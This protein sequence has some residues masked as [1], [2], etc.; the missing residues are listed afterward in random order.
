MPIFQWE[1]GSKRVYIIYNTSLIFFPSFFFGW[2][3]WEGARQANLGHKLGLLDGVKSFWIYDRGQFPVKTINYSKRG[4]NNGF[5]F[6]VAGCYFWSIKELLAS[7]SL[8]T[9][10][11]LNLFGIFRRAVFFGYYFL[12]TVV[13]LVRIFRFFWGGGL[14]DLELPLK[15]EIH[16]NLI[17]V[18]S[19]QE[20]F[21]QRKN[22]PALNWKQYQKNMT[23]FHGNKRVSR[24]IIWVCHCSSTY[25]N[26]PQ[27]T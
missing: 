3:R 16:L 11:L 7:I 14:P 1:E 17:I 22:E 23:L 15:F 9:S 26:S 19:I 8:P 4:Y 25:F 27:H 18:D 6:L 12:V 5:T 2:W 13:A 21:D 24:V 10:P 20:N